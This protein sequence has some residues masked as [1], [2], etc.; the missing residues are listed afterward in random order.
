MVLLSNKKRSG[1]RES[2]VI[3]DED[4]KKGKLAYNE[5]FLINNRDLVRY[6]RTG[7]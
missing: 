3:K 1:L 4:G 7:L 5:V 2:P 6:E